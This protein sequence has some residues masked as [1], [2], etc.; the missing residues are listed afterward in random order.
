MKNGA[1]TQAPFSVSIRNKFAF[2]NRKSESRRAYSAAG[3]SSSDASGVSIS[4]GTSAF[5]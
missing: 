3:A 5:S 2:S 1:L 4:T